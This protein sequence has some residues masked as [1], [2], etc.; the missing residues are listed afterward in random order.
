[1]S[2]EKNNN[3]LGSFKFAGQGFDTY[4]VVHGLGDSRP[5]V[6]VYNDATDFR[7]PDDDMT[8]EVIDINTI[9]I[10]ITAGVTSIRGTVIGSPDPVE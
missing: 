8:L 6:E 2:H 1:M 10:V 3:D 7:I 9:E 4:T 5:V